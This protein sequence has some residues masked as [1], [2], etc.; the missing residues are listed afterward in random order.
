MDTGAILLE[1]KRSVYGAEHSA[2]YSGDVNPL[3]PEF[4]LIS[5]HPV[6]KM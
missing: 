6:C 1:L 5:A 2:P 3:A 4:F